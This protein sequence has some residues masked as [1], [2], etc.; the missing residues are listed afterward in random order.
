MWVFLVQYRLCD[1][2]PCVLSGLIILLQRKSE[3]V[4]LF[5]VCLLVSLPLGATVGL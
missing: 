4:A 5:R 3:L 1:E 2:V